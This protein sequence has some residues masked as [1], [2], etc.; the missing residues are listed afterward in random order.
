[1]VAGQEKGRR[2]DSEGLAILDEASKQ[3]VCPISRDINN[4]FSGL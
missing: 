4:R 3:R 2:G 1:M